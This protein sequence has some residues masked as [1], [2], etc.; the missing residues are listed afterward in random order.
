MVVVVGCL[1]EWCWLVVVWSKNDVP[2]L[3]LYS[4]WV[5]GGGEGAWEGLAVVLVVVVMLGVLVFVVVIVMGVVVLVLLLLVGVVC[6]VGW[7]WM[8][9]FYVGGAG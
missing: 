1:C 2:V 6:G 7:W 8:W 4:R 5:V 9:I 3:V